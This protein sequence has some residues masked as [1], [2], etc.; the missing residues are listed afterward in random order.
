MFDILFVL[1]I[2]I[3]F[4]LFTDGTVTNA[5]HICVCVCMCV[6]NC[7]QIILRDLA[8]HMCEFFIVMLLQT[9][10]NR[11]LMD[12]FIVLSSVDEK[13]VGNETEM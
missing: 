8:R 6:E 7:K 9:V 10:C 11:Y 13:F 5:V 4:K 2:Y 1:S 12:G 3:K